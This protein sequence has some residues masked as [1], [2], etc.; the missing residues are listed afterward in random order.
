VKL[1]AA[2][3]IN[4]REEDFVARVLETTQAHGAD[5]ILDM[6]GGTYAR[7]N[8]DALAM[9]GR[10]VHLSTGN[11]SEFCAP[12]GQ[13]MAKRAVITGS[14][15]RASLL[16]KKIEIAGRLLEHVWPHLGID[17]R[18]VI[19]SVYPLARASEA[20]ARMESGAHIGKIL[21]RV[22]D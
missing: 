17:V 1:G 10:V 8:L 6:A 21:L 4:Y 5:V 22:R 14:M 7:R 12:V 16:S 11:D 19:D 15:L 3:A 18:P 2:L 9:D 13:I 20:H